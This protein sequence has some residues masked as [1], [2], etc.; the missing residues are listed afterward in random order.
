MA[1]LYPPLVVQ[2]FS[3][4]L[5]GS[6]FLLFALLIYLR[7]ALCPSSQPH[8]CCIWK[9]ASLQRPRERC[10]DL[11]TTDS[12]WCGTGFGWALQ[13]GPKSGPCCGAWVCV[14]QDYRCL[15]I[16]L[17]HSPLEWLEDENAEVVSPISCCHIT[18]LIWPGCPKAL[19]RMIAT[20][21]RPP[22]TAG[23]CLATR[24]TPVR[25]CWNCSFSSRTAA[26]YQLLG[27]M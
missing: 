27:V 1:G 15:P 17:R 7:R 3:F 20:P 22:E 10:R 14:Q 24:R 21:C 16:R 4:R 2:M 19:K 25:S 13:P 8:F 26:N 18:S 9:G 23:D 11:C 12:R 6:F 5:D